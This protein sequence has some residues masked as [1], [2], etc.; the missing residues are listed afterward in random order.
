MP[1]RI[2]FSTV[3]IVALAACSKAQK[4]APD[5]MATVAAASETAPVPASATAAPRESAG[6]PVQATAP[7]AAPSASPSAAHLAALAQAKEFGMM[8]LL[9]AGSGDPNAPKAPWG[10]DSARGN[11]WGDEIGDSFGAGGLGLN[12]VGEGKGGRGE[13]IG[14]GTIGTLGHGAGTGTGQGFG[15]GSGRLGGSHHN[16]PPKIRMGATSV[17]GRLPPEVIQRIVR[18]NFGRF[19][20]CYENALKSNPKLEGDITV[21]FTIQGDGSVS[22]VKSSGSLSDEGMT[23]CV[24]KSFS[25]LSFPT[26][27]GGIV[28]VSY[29]LKFSPGEDASAAKLG[30][31]ALTDVRADDVKA[32]LEKA[33]CTEVTRKENPPGVTSPTVFSAK[34]DGRTILVTFV[35]AGETALSDSDIAKL[36]DTGVVRLE[37]GFLLAVTVDR[38]P[39]KSG[40]QALMN[41]LIVSG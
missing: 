21:K 19:R 24:T 37:N 12:G 8:G 5:D 16:A 26:P 30:G 32:A 29:P 9:N 34:K 36:R 1:R 11:M 25:G 38:D 41:A 33:G 39:D 4:A 6:A 17:S 13:G 3:S 31:K 15:S 7:S 22:D 2:L 28:S 35:A 27:E 18:Q 23:S 20:L 14:L 10:A 40:A